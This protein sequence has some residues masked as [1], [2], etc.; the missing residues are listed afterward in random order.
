[1]VRVDFRAVAVGDR[2][3]ERDDDRRLT[4]RIDINFVEEN[5][6]VEVLG[7]GIAAAA[8]KSPSPEMSVVATPSGWMTEGPVHRGTNRLMA[9]VDSGATS[10]STGSDSAAAPGGTVIPPSPP[11]V[12]A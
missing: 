5:L 9:S 3:A 7:E 11:K 6:D 2:V 10:M 12:S 1:M 8:V 4:G